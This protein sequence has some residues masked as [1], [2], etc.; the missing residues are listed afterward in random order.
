[1]RTKSKPI[2]AKT[3]SLRRRTMTL[4]RIGRAAVSVRYDLETLIPGPQ[5]HS[6]SGRS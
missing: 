5:A 2:A 4:H 3:P 6:S 1:M